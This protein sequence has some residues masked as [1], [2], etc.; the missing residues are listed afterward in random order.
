MLTC[1]IYTAREW[2]GERFEA[3]RIWAQSESNR[4]WYF[5]TPLTNDPEED[6][7]NLPRS[8]MLNFEILPAAHYRDECVAAYRMGLA[9]MDEGDLD[10]DWVSASAPSVMFQEP[11]D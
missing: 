7:L 10:R 2:N 3:K 6:L 5:P 8:V 1:L 11:K 4:A 9:L